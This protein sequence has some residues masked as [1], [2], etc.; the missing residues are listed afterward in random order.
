[1]LFRRNCGF[2]RTGGVGDMASTVHI[3]V[4]SFVKI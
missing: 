2:R 1:V 3:N 4:P